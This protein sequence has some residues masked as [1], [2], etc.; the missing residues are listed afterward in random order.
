MADSR[1]VRQI[2]ELLVTLNRAG[3]RDR[4]VLLA[5]ATVPRERFVPAELAGHAWENRPLPIGDDQ[6]ISQP[7][8]VATMT[9]ALR[10]HGTERVLEIGTGSGYQTAILCELSRSV[11]SI[12]RRANLAETAA[13]RLRTLGYRQARVIVADGSRGWPEEAPYDR[14][15]VAAAAPGI[16]PSLLEQLSPED[17]ARLVIPVGTGDNQELIVIERIGGK[18]YRQDLGPVRFVPLIGTEGWDKPGFV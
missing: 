11:I 14:I 3:I 17:G 4:D 2:K 16:P 8:I 13:G 18:L 10:L 9:Q 1:R 7:L 15:I 6:T 12:E 5:I